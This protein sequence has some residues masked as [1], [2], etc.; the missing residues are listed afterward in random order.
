MKRMGS[1][2]A[3]VVW[4]PGPVVLATLSRACMDW[5]RTVEVG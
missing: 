3:W 1:A 4:A 2:V 5:Y